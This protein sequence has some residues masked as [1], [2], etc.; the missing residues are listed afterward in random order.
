[1]TLGFFSSGIK[2]WKKNTRTPNSTF[3][4][5]RGHWSDIKINSV[6]F[7]G[8]LIVSVALPHKDLPYED[9]LEEN[10]EWEIFGSYEKLLCIKIDWTWNTPVCTVNTKLDEKT[11]NFS[12]EL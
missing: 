4:T 2:L 7:A 3:S 9:F 6:L 5:N 11:T 8:K 12:H 1:M 10:K